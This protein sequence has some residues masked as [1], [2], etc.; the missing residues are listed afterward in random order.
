MN[1]VELFIITACTTIVPSLVDIYMQYYFHR[2]TTKVMCE[3]CKKN[4]IE[5]ES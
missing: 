5:N 4:I 1:L 2:R 3:K